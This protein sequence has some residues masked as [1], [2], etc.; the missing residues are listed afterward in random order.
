[1]SLAVL[2]LWHYLL[3]FAVEKYI[4]VSINKY[5]PIITIIFDWL[6]QIDW[7]ID[8]QWLI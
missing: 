2:L 8:Q 4:L 7:L 3:N 1:M 5:F 6:I